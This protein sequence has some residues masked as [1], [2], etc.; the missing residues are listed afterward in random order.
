MNSK[1]TG[2]DDT[3][4]IEPDGRLNEVTCGRE[5]YTREIGGINGRE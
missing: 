5:P 3:T 4:L 2:H 1:L